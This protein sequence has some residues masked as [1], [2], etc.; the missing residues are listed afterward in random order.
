M[1]HSLTKSKSSSSS[2]SNRRRRTLPEAKVRSVA[3]DVLSALHFLHSNRI[4][5]RD[6]KPQNILIDK[7]GKAKIYTLYSIYI[8][9]IFMYVFSLLGFFLFFLFWKNYY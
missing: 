9:V 8:C 7:E 2:S 4:L 5:H 3:C 1:Q 6:V